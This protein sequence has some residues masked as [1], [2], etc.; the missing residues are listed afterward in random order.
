[1]VT[2]IVSERARR[3]ERPTTAQADLDAATP[4]PQAMARGI[5]S[6]ATDRPMAATQVG[7]PIRVRTEQLPA[8]TRGTLQAS[9]LAPAWRGQPVVR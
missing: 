4:A 8:P 1:M 9:D 6:Q 7:Q 3:S 5:P 2:E